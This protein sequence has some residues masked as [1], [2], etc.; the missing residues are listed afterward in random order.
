MAKAPRPGAGKRVTAARAAQT[1]MRI[2]LL[3]QTLEFAPD[4]IPFAVRARLR[5]QTGG[6][7]FS[8]YWAG[9]AAID[10]DSLQVCW[11]VARMVNGEPGLPLA[12][13]LDEWPDTLDLSNED[14]D[15]NDVDVD[16]IEPDDAVNLD[17]DPESSAPS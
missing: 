5:K 16:L 6:L 2:R 17:A 3:D 1:I 12:A 10:T 7:P 15:L 13:V 9:E 14:S 8:A 4:N 11:W